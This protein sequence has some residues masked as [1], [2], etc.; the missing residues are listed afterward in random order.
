MFHHGD[1]GGTLYV[2]RS[3]EVEL[4]FK[5]DTGEHIT[6]ETV[7]AG[8]FFGD[9]TSGATDRRRRK[10]RSDVRSPPRHRRAPK[11]CRTRARNVGAL[12]SLCVICR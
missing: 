11:L 9:M 12:A 5:N 4:F 1:P 10:E 3:G 8:Q 6:L 2:I 7:G